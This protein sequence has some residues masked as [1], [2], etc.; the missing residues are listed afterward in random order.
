M[1]SDTLTITIN[2]VAK[3]LTRINQDGYSSE[4][5]LR[6]SDGSFT[7][8]IRNTSFNDKARLSTGVDRHN[9][10]LI[11][12][13]YPVA[14][15]SVGVKRKAYFVLENDQSDSTTSALNFDLGLLAFGTSANVTKLLNR[16][17]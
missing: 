16:E 2:S 6:E 10:E 15:S 11:H 12:Q 1:F 7:L 3:V 5:F 9:V 13:L 8:R 17:S 4:Y 14:P